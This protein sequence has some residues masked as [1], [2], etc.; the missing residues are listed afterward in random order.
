MNER[1][2]TM[3]IVCS[4]HLKLLVVDCIG[5]RC[6]REGVPGP[7]GLNVVTIDGLI[8]VTRQVVQRYLGVAVHWPAA[9][10]MF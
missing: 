8:D 1:T 10:P 9:R 5:S 3:H 7:P 6:S 4:I 2:H